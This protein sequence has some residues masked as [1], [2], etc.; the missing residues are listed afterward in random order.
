MFLE[1]RNKKDL[2]GKRL[3]LRSARFLLEISTKASKIG[4][5]KLTRYFGAFMLNS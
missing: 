4:T 3:P 1:A 5:I 2:E